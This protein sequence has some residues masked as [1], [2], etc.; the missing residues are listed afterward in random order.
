MDTAGSDPV[1]SAVAQQGVLLGQHET[2]L[3][4]T[5]REVEYLV[6]QVAD[7]TARVQEL[8][9]EADQSGSA[10]F[11]SRLEP[12]PHC[13][14]PPAYDGDP[15]SCRAF[16][17]QCSVVFT[18]QP[19]TG[20]SSKSQSSSVKR[21]ILVST[22]PFLYSPSS[23]TLLPVLVEFGGASHLCSALVDSGAEGN[24]MDSS[25]AAQWGIPSIALSE[26]IPAR[27]L[28][29]T[30]ITTI[31]FVTPCVNL[32]VSGNHREVTTLYLLDSPCAPII[33][34]HPWLVQHG[35]HVDWSRNSVLS[36]S[37]SC[38][39]S[40]LGSAPFPGSVCPVFQVAPADLTGVPTEY[41]DLRLV[42]SKSRATSLPPHRPPGSK[43][44]KP[45]ALS[46][47]FEA[48]GEEVS[49]DTIL[50]KGVVVASLSWGV[51][52]RVQEA[53]RECQVPR[54]G[55]SGRL[56]VPS[57]LR[58][59]VI[60]WGHSSRLVCHPGV[61]RSLAA[62]RQRFW[63]PSMAKDAVC[64]LPFPFLFNPS[65]ASPL[66]SEAPSS[67]PARLTRSPRSR[68]PLAAAPSHLLVC[69]YGLLHR[70]IV[71]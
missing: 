32:V 24:F 36:W 19:R 15:N 52:R 49:N 68:I 8:Q 20:L 16:L 71:F 26:S 67:S 30:V 58:S 53:L 17:T 7:L 42:F 45:D 56:F 54:G 41:H 65:P 39:A 5:S 55:P 10:P 50:P 22:V 38:L 27:S 13:N 3:T 2:R 60:Q 59:E 37:P 1:R 48:P 62:I 33:L 14:N 66:Q 11:S 40:C 12:E 6:S 29:G 43:N 63:W 28:S 31:S 25:I 21:G 70:N 34:G 46:R 9:R 57:Q 23:R 47:L 18:L 61:R 51:E 35:P 4:H 69:A 44:T 64:F